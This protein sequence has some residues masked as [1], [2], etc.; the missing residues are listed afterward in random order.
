ADGARPRGRR[1]QGEHGQGSHP[2]PHS[3]RSPPARPSGDRQPGGRDALRG[4]PEEVPM[5]PRVKEILGWYGSDSPGTLTNLARL[6][7]HGPL[8]GSGRLK[9]NMEIYGA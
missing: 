8:R 1:G 6:L 9:T 4:L 3:R 2:R 5:T 7:N